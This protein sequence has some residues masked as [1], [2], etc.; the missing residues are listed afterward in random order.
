MDEFGQ[1]KENLIYFESFDH[2]IEV[3]T[4]QIKSIHFF[5]PSEKRI[6]FD[7]KL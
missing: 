1:L 4:V 3:E 7:M 2:F 6:Y 5:H